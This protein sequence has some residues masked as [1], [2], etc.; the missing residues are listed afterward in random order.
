MRRYI[1]AN[2]PGATYFFTLTL[3]ERGARTLVD[4]IDQLRAAVTHVKAAHPFQIDAMVVLPD[5]LHALWT[6][7]QH[8]ADFPLRWQLIKRGFTK[9]LLA[10]GQ[11]DSCASAMRGR[12]ERTLWQ[13]RYWEHLV[14]DDADFGRHVDYI[15]F[16]PVKHGMVTRAL[17][18]PHSSFH[19]FVRNGRLPADWGIAVSA[20]GEFGE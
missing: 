8:D 18:W 7:P 12:G 10:D 5:H 13:R 16:N 11:L 2:T 3:Q 14:R 1:R 6:L 20:P 15:H 9:R 19:R 4:H 17:E